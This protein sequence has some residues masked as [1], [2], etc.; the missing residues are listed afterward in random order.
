MYNHAPENYKCPLC[1]L[2]NGI[3]N[4][5]TMAKQVDIVYRDDLVVAI[6]NSKFVG[7]NP[8]HVIVMPAKH[9]ENLYELEPEYA[10]RIID[11]SQKLAKAIKEVRKCD[12]IMIKQVNEPAA[13]QA[14]FHYHM[15]IVP[16]FK[17]DNYNKEIVNG[18]ERVSDPSERI[19]YAK[20]LKE[21]LKNHN[22]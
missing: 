16:R 13:G 15:H 2:V 20:A 6:I 7:N 12:G 4:E 21:Y 19:P 18:N 14:A 8:G 5:H 9:F 3:E 17:D 10:H 22:D 1:L 11:I